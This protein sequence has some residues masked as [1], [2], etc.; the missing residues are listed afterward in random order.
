ML[1]HSHDSVQLTHFDDCIGDINFAINF[2]LISLTL[3]EIITN[4]C[5]YITIWHHASV[6]QFCHVAPPSIVLHEQH[7]TYCFDILLLLFVL[8]NAQAAI[9]NGRPQTGNSLVGDLNEKLNKVLYTHKY[10]TPLL[11]F[12]F[13]PCYPWY[14]LL[15]VCKLTMFYANFGSNL[16]TNS[17]PKLLCFVW[18]LA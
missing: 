7:Y 8:I 9:L 16:L 6:N 14:I 15:P 13:S 5:V 11:H 1:P 4:V 18:F 12:V 2:L 17:W 10:K 3:T